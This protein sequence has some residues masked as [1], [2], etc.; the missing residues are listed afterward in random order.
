MD[1]E[2]RT[3]K[4]ALEGGTPNTG[5][6]TDPQDHRLL[7]PDRALAEDA[8]MQKIARGIRQLSDLDPPDSLVHTVM[9][10]VKTLRLPLRTRFFRW[11]RSPHSITFTP[12]RLAPAAVIGIALCLVLAFH[13]HDSEKGSLVVQGDRVPVVLALYLPQAR[14]VAVIGSFNG[15]QPQNCELKTIN[16]DSHWTV[17]L[18]LSSGRYEYAFLVDGEKIIPDPRAG[19][20]GDDGFGNTNAILLVGNGNGDSV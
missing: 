12:L 20:Y 14:S 19:L 8:G 16:G 4:I 2:I 11:I 5:P 9:Y 3:G 18:R 7:P 13:I 17:T 15:W 10:S 1:K 6:C